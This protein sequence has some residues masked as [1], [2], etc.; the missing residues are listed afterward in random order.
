MCEVNKI[1]DRNIANNA[2][3]AGARKKLIEFLLALRM[4][5]A[6]KV[7]L[8]IAHSA[9]GARRGG[10]R[11][12]CVGSLKFFVGFGTPGKKSLPLNQAAKQVSP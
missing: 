9:V 3:G 12:E 2:R 10:K 8:F 1:D 5:S 6:E 4:K 7:F 11:D